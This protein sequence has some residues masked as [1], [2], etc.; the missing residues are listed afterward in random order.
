[1]RS[2]LLTTGIIFALF[3]AMHV[4]ITFEHW[5]QVGPEAESVLAPAVVAIASGAL[6]FWAF[7]VYARQR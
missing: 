7:R 5:R 6:G 4:F 1:M 2:Y 3:A